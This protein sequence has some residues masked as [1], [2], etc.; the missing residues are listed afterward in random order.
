MK[1]RTLIIAVAASPVALAGCGVAEV[2]TFPTIATALTALDALLTTPLKSTGTWTLPQVLEHCAQSIEGSLSGFPQMKSAWF[3]ATAGAAA[4][5]VFSARGA[6]RHPLADPIPGTAP[7]TANELEAPLNRLVTAF[8]TFE[9]YTGKLHPHF[10]YGELTKSQYTAA[11]LMHLANHWTEMVPA[12][13]PPA[14]K[15]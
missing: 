15:S 8:K 12:N 13:A 2:K 10:A 6:M 9:A 14:A 4:F 1:R 7:L 5:S 11:H 3:R